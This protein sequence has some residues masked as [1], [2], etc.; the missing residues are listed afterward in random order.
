MTVIH[1]KAGTERPRS[2][3][4]AQLAFHYGMFRF[5]RTHYATERSPS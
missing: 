2:Q 1:V 4:A 3:A 5:Y